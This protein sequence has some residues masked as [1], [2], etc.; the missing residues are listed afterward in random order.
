MVYVCDKNIANHKN[1][2]LLLPKSLSK[3]V[4][5]KDTPYLTRGFMN[6]WKNPPRVGISQVSKD[7]VGEQD[8]PEP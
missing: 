2:K 5:Q 1:A 6:P 8:C 3:L 7:M 4:S